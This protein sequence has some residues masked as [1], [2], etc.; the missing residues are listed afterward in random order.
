M[1]QKATLLIALLDAYAL[2][3]AVPEPTRYAVRHGTKPQDHQAPLAAP[4][5]AITP[6][7]ALTYPTRTRMHRRNIIDDVKSDVKSVLTQLG[8][9]IPSYVADGVA[10]FFQDFPS[11]SAVQTSLGLSDE[12]LA[13]LPTNVLNIPPYG[14]W[15]D[16]GWNVRFHG[17]VYKQPNTTTE[18]LNDL[19][20][21]FLIGT[22]I[23]DLPASQQDQARNLT[24]SIFV[25]QQGNE[26][27]SMH[28]EPAP[29]QGASGQSGGSGAVTPSGG[30]QNLTLPYNTTGEGDF[31]VFLPIANTTG[32]LLAG[33]ETQEIQRLNVYANGS[34]LGNAT[35][36]LVPPTGLTVISDIDDILRVTKIY[37]P[38]E[39]LLNSFA[40]P[41]T[42]WLNM[43][44]IYQNWSDSLPNMHFHYLTTT[45]EQV[46]RNYMDFIYKTYPGGSFDTR[47]LNFSDVDATLSIRKF[48]LD[49]IFQTFPQRKFILVADTSNSDVM[50][51]YP[52]MA[53][54]Y[55]GQVQCIFLRN[56]SA[57][58]DDKFPYDT[59]G[60]KDLN[61]QSYMFF[62][63]PD[64][65]T[66]LDIAGGKCYNS[67]ILQN[68]TFGT[69]D[70][71]L[72]IHGAA[73]AVAPPGKGGLA[74]LVVALGVAML[75][76]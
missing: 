20:N 24:A 56:T 32:G 76:L 27:V 13:A 5:P 19:A 34:D 53:K 28:L 37:Q 2:A 47:P 51:D 39:G 4:D 3:A 11:G 46:T 9:D 48:L 50:K 58:D 60:F 74:G 64:D 29:E 70:E 59:S 61:Q 57:T 69:Q 14:N 75:I 65:L 16:Q 6:S 43:P 36:Y 54:Q 22:D 1:R 68:V 21:V 71:L 31:D 49:K 17:N 10:N 30:E 38:K 15:T 55:P 8:S 63:V 62:K 42:P 72:G 25:V 18:K 45:P 35:A 44:S 7:P 41:F 26:T 52:Q 33:N 12:Q 73:A 23:Q 67:T 66:N 40:R